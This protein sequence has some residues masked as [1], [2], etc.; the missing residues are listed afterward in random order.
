MTTAL[1]LAA[2]DAFPVFVVFAVFVASTL[3]LAI[4]VTTDRVTPG[5]F[6]ISDGRLTPARNGIALFGDYMSAATLLGSPG[7]IALTGY[8]GIPYLLGPIV[9]WVVMLLLVAEPYHSTGRFTIGDSLAR[10]LR[11][12]PV[13]RAAGVA[14]LVIC[15]VYLVAQLVGAGALAAPILGLEGQGA[16]QVMVASLGLLM[17]I[18]VVIGGMRAATVIQLVKAVILLGGGAFLAFLVMSKFSWNPAG[19][20]NR[21]AGS[22]GL[23][24]AFLQPGVRYGD[25]R[26]SKLDSL[27]LQLAVLLGAAGL[28]HLLMR[29][30][31]VPTARAARGSVQWATYLTLAFCLLA[32][33]MGFGAVALLGRGTITADSASGNSAT[34]LLAEFLGGAF[35][36]TLVSCVAFTTVL[37]VVAGLV[38]TASTALAHDVYQ[39]GFKNGKASQKSELLVAKGSVLL[40]GLVGTVLS[41]YAQGLN[42][43]FMVGLAF[44]VAGSA[45][46]PALLYSMYWKG[47]TTRGALWSIYGGL[48]ASV[49]LVLLSPAVSGGPTALLPEADFAFFPLSNPAVVSIPLGFLLGSLGSLLDP[50]EVDGAEFTEAEVRI[51]AGAGAVPE[52]EPAAGAPPDGPEPAPRWGSR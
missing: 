52:Y 12:R 10:R 33:V 40:I 30:G 49:G 44:A 5:D 13:H 2:S 18:Y 34:L 36:V 31:A 19:L 37:A 51:L 20:L 23:G 6:Y 50:R 7:V 28:P 3:L 17:I 9:A 4:W 32:G 22:S 48:F 21:A 8:D 16:R 26:V 38:L 29:L 11:P 46:L 27:S 39:V 14:T 1:P 43:S 41:M 47:F 24:D 42:I 45:I 25:D 35:L 15:L